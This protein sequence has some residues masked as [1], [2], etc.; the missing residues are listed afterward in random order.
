M[1][2]FT[3]NY[4]ALANQLSLISEYS[5]VYKLNSN[6]KLNS[7]DIKNLILMNQE[8][9]KQKLE[10]K[11]N[12]VEETKFPQTSYYEKKLLV[13]NFS[14]HVAN[15]RDYMRQVRYVDYIT[16]ERNMAKKRIQQYKDFIE[17]IKFKKLI[18]RL[19]IKTSVFICSSRLAIKLF[20]KWRWF[21]GKYLW[22]EPLWVEEEFADAMFVCYVALHKF[23]RV[24]DGDWLI[25]KLIFRNLLSN[26]Q[27]IIC[28][29][30]LFFILYFFVRCGQYARL[31]YLEGIALTEIRRYE[32][33]YH[34][35]G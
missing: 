20:S 34:S 18:L 27:D 10:V 8:K 1:T 11:P 33:Y 7:S 24:T 23:V 12:T 31:D 26:P 14:L 3:A 6:Y 28:L 32:F 25:T 22:E 16:H 5:T 19:Q 9:N 35:I 17:E 4:L 13:E 21:W 29:T 15:Y 2:Y 30:D